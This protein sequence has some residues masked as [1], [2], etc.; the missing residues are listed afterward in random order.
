[1]ENKITVKEVAKLMGTS[2][3]FIRIGL[4]RKVLPFGVAM[5]MP[6]STKYIY[7]I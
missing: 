5:K 2:E 7:Y 6:N 1:M 3:M 4:Q